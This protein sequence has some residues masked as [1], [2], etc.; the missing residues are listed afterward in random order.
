MAA[1]KELELY[2]HIPFC[3]RKCN[4]CDFLS[5]PAEMGIRRNYVDKL[6]EEIRQQGISCGDYRVVSVFLGGGTPSLLAGVQ[7]AEIMEAVQDSF[8]VSREAEVTL[9]CNPGT[10]TGEK[11]TFYRSAGINRL[12]LGLQSAD[13]RELRLL[14]RIHAYEDFLES[15]DLARKKGFS[16]IN[17][18][19]MSALPGQT[20]D[21]WAHTLKKV[22]EL[23]PEHISAYSLIVEEGTPFYEQYGEDELRREQGETP[24]ALPTEEVEREM[25]EMTREMLAK[26]GYLRYEISN[27]ALPGRECRHNIGYWTLT[28]YLGLGLGSSS[29]MEDV[30]F[31]NTKDLSDYLDGKYISLPELFAGSRGQDASYLE[32]DAVYLDKHQKMEE[33]MFLGLRMAEGISRERF[34]ELFGVALE[35]VY[36][37]V[38]QKLQRQDLLQLYGNMVSLTEQG[39]AVSNYVFREFIGTLG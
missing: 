17:V 32:G 1:E 26:R 31:S 38:L 35:S 39:I 3:V 16:N 23:R 30:R 9:E 29:F 21:D 27:Y 7:I 4:Y 22:T 20:P 33:F 19:L 14:G 15:F 5:M 8:Q 25:Y 28:P 2:I 6:T 12:S 36:G 34:E 24:L 11:L 18:D 37:D 10:L 13:N